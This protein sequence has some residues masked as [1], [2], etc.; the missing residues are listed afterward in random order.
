MLTRER[1]RAEAERQR[2]DAERQRADEVI[3]RYIEKLEKL[4]MQNSNG[5]QE[6]T[7]SESA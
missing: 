5:S 7:T 2:R 6:Q 3:K 1:Q 4:A